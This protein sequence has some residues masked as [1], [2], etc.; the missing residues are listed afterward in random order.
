MVH[1]AD[2]A[3]YLETV[4]DTHRKATGQFFTLPV[5]AN[6]MVRWVL[7]SGVVGIHDP[8]FGLGSFLDATPK[9]SHETFTGSEIDPKI[10][11]YWKTRASSG[12]T[13]VLVR[14]EDYLLS[15]GRKYGNIVCNPPY[16]R[17]QKFLNRKIVF[18]EF[19]KR[20]NIRLPGYINTASAFLLKSLGELQPRGRLA[21]IM[22]LEFLNT[23]YGK[24]V[25]RKLIADS[26]LKAIISLD[27]ERDVFPDATTSVGIILYDSAQ[28]FSS[29]KFFKAKSVEALD[30]IL[31]SRPTAEVLHSQITPED[32]W[33][34]YFDDNPIAFD[35]G[36]TVALAHYGRFSRGIAT[37][38]NKFFV[39]KPSRVKELGLTASEV[40]PSITRSVQVSRHFFTGADYDELVKRDERVL[41]F[42]ANGQ[43]SDNASTY[44][45]Y[46]ELK[47]FNQGFI[48]KRRT[49][50][51]KMEKRNPSPL[52]LGV[53][54]RGGYK[55]VR[56]KAS[57]VNLTCFHGF[58]PNIWGRQYIDHLFLYLQSATGREITSLSMRRYGDALDKFEPNDLNKAPVPTTQFFDEIPYQHIRVALKQLEELGDMPDFV[59]SWFDN[60]RFI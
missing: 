41:L 36:K 9:E 47:G 11:D 39:L 17:F 51:Y 57:V 52:W 24:M 42:N 29:A 22:P 43:I 7:Q 59:E 37:G 19:E 25:K 14:Q 30:T 38:A 26:H 31:D 20:L 45:R 16:M 55:V 12:P 35:R 23:G 2:A 1:D 15:W 13:R 53:F 54:S 21:Y 10:L 28:K 56:N 60:L 8:G 33:L 48:T 5:V 4:G 50:W 6:F 58:Q 44:I 46:G 40:L 49:P 32:N 34:L 27:C 18:Q 3:R